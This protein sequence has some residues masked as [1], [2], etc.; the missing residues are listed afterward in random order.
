MTART[1]ATA[2]PRRS[3][4]ADT[5]ETT[6][7]EAVGLSKQYGRHQ[8]LRDCTVTIPAG[9]VA[10]LVGPNGSGKTTFL[11]L[12]VGLSQ[13]TSGEVAVF[14][15]TVGRDARALTRVAFLAQEKP[16]YRSF[17][18]REML[19]F[20]RDLNP[21][22]DGDLARRRLEEL[23]I[24]LDRKVGRLSGG[25]Q[26][27]VALTLALAKRPSLLVLDEPLADLDPLARHDVTRHLMAAVAETGLTVLLS[28]HVVPDLADTCDWLVVLNRGRVQV[29]GDIDELLAGHHLL[30]GPADSADAVAAEHQVVTR[31]TAGRQTSLLVRG[32][33]PAVDPRW[34]GRPVELEEL[35]LTYLRDPDAT[36][37][38]RRPATRQN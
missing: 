19:R 22:W 26:T 17:R 25:Q 24:P 35:V 21:R 18:V 28:S 8:A 1:E 36:A 2:D 3:G 31:H 38:P 23:E 14:G 29:S 4:A 6:A 7:L 9:R 16:L 34:T 13:P 5:T 33:G 32:S 27:Q 11:H 15:G 10:A 30:V 20:G 37:L 12:V